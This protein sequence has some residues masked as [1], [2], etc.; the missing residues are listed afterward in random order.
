MRSE[1]KVFGSNALRTVLLD[2]LPQFD[3]ANGVSTTVDFGSTNHTLEI[4]RAGAVA[5]LIIATSSA[6]DELAGEGKIISGT[7]TDL[8]MAGIGACVRA[9]QPR[10]D[11]SSVEAL[12]RTLLEV[13]SVA[14]SKAGQSGIHFAKVIEQLGIADIVIAKAKIGSGGLIGEIV[15]RGEAEL[16]FQQASEILAVKG[17]DLIGLLPDAVQLNS[18]FAAGIGSGT[19]QR[20]AAQ[21]LIQQLG[22]AHAARIMRGNGLTPVAR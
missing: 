18:L 20:K 9:G 22:T 12:K 4:M 15:L 2:C 14:Y 16:G 10:P 1:F 19:Q 17:V 7:K 21:A 13:P 5:D 11:I 6:I 3:R 8:A